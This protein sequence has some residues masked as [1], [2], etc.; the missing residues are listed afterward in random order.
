MINSRWLF[1]AA[2]FSL[3]GFAGVSMEEKQERVQELM[4]L[5]R[6]LPVASFD[7]YRRE[8]DYER[9]GLSLENRAK[10]ETNLLAQQ[11]RQRVLEAYEAALKNHDNTSAAKQE[12]RDAIEADLELA[13]PE[14]RE[15]IRQLA[16]DALDKIEQGAFYSSEVELDE[17]QVVMMKKVAV[18][19]DY[20]NHENLSDQTL[21]IANKAKDSEK[22]E[23][24]NKEELTESLI[25]DRES[26]RFVSTASQTV[27]T[28]EIVTA[29]GDLSLQVKMEFLG[30]EIEA[31]PSITFKRSLA[32]DAIIMAEDLNPVILRDGNFDYVKRDSM[33]R[34][35]KKNGKP[36][37]RYISFTCDVDLNFETDYAGS[38]GFKYMGVGAGVSASKSF[39]N[40]V[41]ITSRRIALPEI[42]S[43]KSVTVKFISEL[44]QH[45]FVRAKVTSQL[46]VLQSLNVMMRN[47]VSGLRFSH[48]RTKCAEDSHCANW[49]NNEVISLQKKKKCC[50]LCGARLRKI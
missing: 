20:L 26:S 5:T 42:V 41:T 9:R 10:A 28:A 30:A 25:S 19:S 34:I 49:Y 13:A 7:G 4:E 45:D 6:N 46:T 38:G 44:C 50:P 39:S 43:G 3:S 23:F 24:R 22:K 48:A 11:V 35:I 16:L 15:E 2:L 12:V 40:T 37:K 18:R 17:V 1:C 31:G 33:N 14:L 32:T 21:P 36:V 47:V 29:Q 8:L 27:K